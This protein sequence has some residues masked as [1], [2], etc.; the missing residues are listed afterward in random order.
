MEAIAIYLDL[1][2]ADLPITEV[3][4][5]QACSSS[6]ISLEFA[7]SRLF[8]YYYGADLVQTAF[9]RHRVS[10]LIVIV[11]W[12]GLSRAEFTNGRGCASRVVAGL[13]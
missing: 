10:D 4:A 1:L 13:V 3:V 8:F 9:G 2:Y 7:S 6:T 11:G 5:L 12:A